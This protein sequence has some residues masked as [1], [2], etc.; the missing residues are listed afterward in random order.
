MTGTLGLVHLD[1]HGVSVAVEG[2][3]DDRCTWP[4]V[5]PLTQYSSRLRDQ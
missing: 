5:S 2:D 4:E 3:G 1:E